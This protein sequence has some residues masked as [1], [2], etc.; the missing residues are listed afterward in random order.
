MLQPVYLDNGIIEIHPLRDKD[1]TKPNNIADDLFEILND[2]ENTRFIAEKRI[3]SKEALGNLIFGFM[4][5]Y[6]EQISYAHFLTLK[7]IDKVIGVVNVI[8]PERIEE[9]YNIK[10]K[11]FIEYYLN[12]KYWNKGIMSG[13]IEAII[14]TL[15]GQGIDNISA[16]CEKGNLASIKILKKCGFNETPKYISNQIYFELG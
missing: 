10:D 3:D 16:I 9:T 4:M 13:A 11:W 12:K 14:S 15:R 7:S 8:S 5:G 1:L 2:S 6:Q